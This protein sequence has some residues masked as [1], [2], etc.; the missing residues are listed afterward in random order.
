MFKKCLKEALMTRISLSQ[1]LNHTM[2]VL[3]GLSMVALLVTIRFTSGA[4]NPLSVVDFTVPLFAV[5]F[6][7][8]GSFLTQRY[9]TR[10]SRDCPFRGALGIS[11]F[12]LYL[13][14]LGMNFGY[15]LSP[16]GFEAI[17]RAV[18]VAG[19]VVPS[20]LVGFFVAPLVL[21]FTYFCFLTIPAWIVSSLVAGFSLRSLYAKRDYLPEIA[22]G[23]Q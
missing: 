23:A 13:L 18:K 19:G 3:L 20:F 22:G 2:A 1:S 14:A 12:Y 9:L 21:M 15:L 17:T 5:L 4:G 11:L 6:P 10:I 7:L 16:G 8:A